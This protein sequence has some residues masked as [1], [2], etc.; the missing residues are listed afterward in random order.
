[1]AEDYSK[2]TEQ[3]LNDVIGNYDQGFGEEI[4][5]VS[6][7]E[8][9]F[10]DALNAINERD[11]RSG[12]T[13]EYFREQLQIT[14]ESFLET[15][16]LSSKIDP[17]KPTYTER[18]FRKLNNQQFNDFKNNLD[19][20]AEF[21][22]APINYE[23]DLRAVQKESDRRD[24]LSQ[25]SAKKPAIGSPEGDALADKIRLD[26]FN[27]EQAKSKQNTAN[28]E[29]RAR[30]EQK[31]ADIQAA[32]EA[33]KVKDSS[34]GKY[35][36]T[37]AFDVKA[38]KPKSTGSVNFSQISK[39]IAKE[40]LAKGY[41]QGPKHVGNASGM[42]APGAPI[43]R[44]KSEAY[45]LTNGGG[46]DKIANPLYN[47]NGKAVPK[48]QTQSKSAVTTKSN[49]KSNFQKI[50]TSKASSNWKSEIAKA[51]G[52]NLRKKL[53]NV[54]SETIN[55]SLNN[56]AI[57]I[58]SGEV[59][60][61]SFRNATA[62]LNEL[63][64]RQEITKAQA[65]STKR[66]YRKLLSDFTVNPDGT[67]EGTFKSNNQ[68]YN[69]EKEEKEEERKKLLPIALKVKSSGGGHSK[70]KS[71]KPK[72]YNSP[73]KVNSSNFSSTSGS[74]SAT[75]I[76]SPFG[77]NKSKYYVGSKGINALFSDLSNLID[78]IKFDFAQ[79][80]FPRLV[81]ATPA[82]SGLARKSWGIS[83]NESGLPNLGVLYTEEPSK[84]NPFGTKLQYPEYKGSSPK[85][86][87]IP[88]DVTNLPSYVIGSRLFYLN[89]LNQGWSDQAIAFYIESI[90]HNTVENF[91]NNTLANLV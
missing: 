44:N 13:S 17:T 47:V 5:T 15:N 69:R 38:N 30:Q 81:K 82:D 85:I 1:M 9:D 20:V 32:N 27:A 50:D 6:F 23:T 37:S 65:T 56:L 26:R 91:K 60:K 22:D 62:H 64:R 90:V 43:P 53:E 31:R 18:E 87:P 41:I 71:Y 79:E 58:N 25:Q 42:Y 34:S 8:S 35:Q 29:F 12:E 49:A 11:K 24:A 75:G 55:G 72:S 70:P 46:V 39:N 14:K 66:Q 51:E 86:K 48:A 73:G 3:E 89:D 84:K 78:D 19:I 10:D 88:R 4:G 68:R 57:G 63:V 2:Y 16:D 80:V 83:N 59:N 61:N 52:V 76:N 74:S 7:V 21:E 54:S 77:T 33:K 36:Q 40:Q 67:L 45:K 28:A